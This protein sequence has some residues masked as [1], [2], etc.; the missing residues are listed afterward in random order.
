MVEL[1]LFF[2]KKIYYPQ[3]NY[4]KNEI[5]ESYVTHDNFYAFVLFL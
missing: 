2:C 3:N 4:G 1:Y 5:M